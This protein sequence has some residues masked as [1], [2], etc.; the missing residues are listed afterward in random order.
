MIPMSRPGKLPDIFPLVRC[1]T[2]PVLDTA[3]SPFD[4]SLVA[5]AGEDGRVA[6]T[7]VDES[8]FEAA[9]SGDPNVQDIECLSGKKMGH[10]RKAGNLLWHPTAEGV[11]ASASYEVKLWD[12]NTQECKIELQTQPDM[13]G[14]MSFSYNGDSLAT[15][16]K[17]KKLRIYD[18]RTNGAAHTTVESHGGV[19][20][21]PLCLLRTIITDLVDRLQSVLDGRH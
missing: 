3:W 19:K 1:H 16:C 18:T 20:G 11:L 2:A 6:V 14:S 17:D 21:A 10:G 4:D 8:M 7:R 9:F 12:I 5:S 13:V 15:T